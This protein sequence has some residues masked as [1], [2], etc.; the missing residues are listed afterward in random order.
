MYYFIVNPN[1]RSGK[2]RL[3]WQR[4]RRELGRRK[5]SYKCFL[6][7][8]PGHAEKIAKQI[9]SLGTPGDPVR[10]IVMGGDGTIH[11]VLTGIEDLS[12]VVFGFIPTG[13]GND[14]CR[15]MKIP[16]DPSE[17][18]KVVL[19]HRTV[20]LMDVP[21]IDLEGRACRFGI[22]AGIGYDAAVCQEVLSS[23]AK[24]ILNRFRLGKLVYLYV[25]LKQILFL[26]PV[27]ASIHLDGGRS[28]SFRKLY[29]AAVMNQKYEGGGFCFCPQAKTNDGVL[30]V[31]AVEGLPR[32]A[33]L[34]AMP[35]AFWGGH[36]SVPGVH[37]FRCTRAEIRT[38]SPMAVHIDGES[39]G[40]R[41]SLTAA[42]EK[43]Q[44][45]IILP[46]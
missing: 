44:L 1:S 26:N 21:Y 34:A 37:I 40:V 14:F 15:G 20:R 9:S 8:Y 13:S 12:A 11:E 33:M 42:L 24:R 3:V 31:I 29:F 6:T 35:S 23:P 43:K 28:W 19:D 16:Q 18:L 38:A 32:L 4:I 39:G 10:M 2:G 41:R 45:K 17:A 7:R 25:A 22:S 30:N 36:T 27:P 46:S 5:I